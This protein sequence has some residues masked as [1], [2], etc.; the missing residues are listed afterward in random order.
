[1]HGSL[2]A[3]DAPSPVIQPP[4]QESFGLPIAVILRFPDLI[5]AY[6]G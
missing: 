2:S 6:C 3:K 4:L 5:T 1:M